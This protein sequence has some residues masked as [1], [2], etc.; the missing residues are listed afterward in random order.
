MC[1][2]W[3]F[4]LRLTRLIRTR[5]PAAIWAAKPRRWNATNSTLRSCFIFSTRTSLLIYAGDLVTLHFWTLNGS[6]SQRL[7]CTNSTLSKWDLNTLVQVKNSP[8]WESVGSHI[9][10]KLKK[11]GAKLSSSCYKIRRELI[12]CAALFALI[13]VKKSL[14]IS[15]RKRTTSDKSI[16]ARHKT[17]T[18]VSFHT[19][20]KTSGLETRVVTYR[21]MSTS[22]SQLAVPH[23]RNRA[24]ASR[25]SKKAS[26][27]SIL[28]N[29]TKNP[30]SKKLPKL[31]C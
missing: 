20:P 4:R 17:K 8:F 21:I 23:P 29:F 24:S 14:A 1:P 28:K 22:P 5:S 30:E 13:W 19:A 6:S 16:T 12:W 2:S 27:A 18:L 25:D 26:Q 9:S 11:L 31:W 3:R 10:I 15:Q 7:A